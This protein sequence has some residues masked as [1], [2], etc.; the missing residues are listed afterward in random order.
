M[1]LEPFDQ[2]FAL[3]CAIATHRFHCE[4]LGHFQW[5]QPVIIPPK[6]CHY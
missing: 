4:G 5:I 1:V 6:G 3:W 2:S